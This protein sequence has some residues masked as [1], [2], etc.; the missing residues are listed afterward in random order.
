MLE[1]I[2]FSSIC[3]WSDAAQNPKGIEEI[4]SEFKTNLQQHFEPL[5][6]DLDDLQRPCQDFSYPK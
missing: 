2:S 4:V 5:L 3:I 1:K 6:E